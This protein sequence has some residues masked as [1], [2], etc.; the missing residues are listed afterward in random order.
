[1]TLR[2]LVIESQLVPPRQ[3]R[4]ILRRPRLEARLAAVLDY[5]LTLVQA[6]TGYGKSTALSALQGILHA[7][8]AGEPGML[9][10]YT[11]NETDRDPL[12]FLAHVVRAFERRAPSWGEPS[13]DIL[14]ASG[15][16]VTTD[17]LIPLINMLTNELDG[18]AILVLDDYHLVADVPEIEALVEYLVDY[19]PPKLHVVISGR[20]PPPLPA[21]SRWRAKGQ[22]LVVTRADL[23]FTVEEIEALFR[24]Q[25]EHPISREQAEVLAAETEGWAI[26]LQMVWQSLESSTAPSLDAALRLLPSSMEALFDYLAQE[27]LARQP[28]A[29]QRFL[30]TTSVLR[31]MDGASCDHLL[32]VQGSADTLRRLHE[33]GLFIVSTGDGAYRYHRLFHDF[34]RAHLDRTS[35]PDEVRGLHRRAADHFQRTGHAEETIHHLLEAQEHDRVA[36]SLEKIGPTLVR[37]GRFDSLSAWIARLPESVRA[38]RPGLN[39]LMGDTLRLRARFDEAL[40]HY[41]AAERRFV[42][43][44]DRLGHSRALRGQAQ[45]FLDTVR[46]LRA[47]SLLEQAL[48][49]LEPQ[50]HPQETAALLDQLAEN[51]LNLGYPDEAELLHREAHLLRSE[52]DP[53]SVFL[54]ARAKMRT[55]RLAEA[56]RLLEARAETDRQTAEFRPQRFHRE[57]VLLLSLLYALNGDADAA[58]RYAREGI[59]IGQ[60]LRS[61]YVEAVGYMRLG[62]AVQLQESRPWDTQERSVSHR[63]AACYHQAIQHIRTFNVLRTQVEPLWGLCLAHGAVGD[64]PSAERYALQALSIASRAGDQWIGNLV[65]LAMGTG[66]ALAGQSPQAHQWLAEA[67]EGFEKVGDMFGQS[68]AW[69]WQALDAW[70]RG[71]GDAALEHLARLLPRAREQGYD[72]LLVRRTLMGLKDDQAAA[73]LLIEAR[74]R[75]IEAEYADHLLETMHLAHIEHHPGYTLSVRTLGSFGVWRGTEPLGPRDWKR[76][77]AR[78]IFQ[79]LLTYRGQW[80]HREQIVEHLWPH[81]PPDAAARDFKVAL[82][83]LNHAL[84][85]GRLHGVPPFFVIRRDTLYGLNPDA[86]VSVDVDDFQRLAASDDA[87]SLRAALDLYEDDYLPDSLYEDWSS[88]LRQRLQHLY[89]DA[90]ERLAR[91]HLQAEAWDEA[92]QVCHAILAR[93]NCWEAAYRLLMQAYAAQENRPRVHSTYERCAAVLREELGVEPSPATQA[94]FEEL[95]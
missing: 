79:L 41:S 75:G 50:K 38:A 3:R 30:L 51:K 18:E 72:S 21:L 86:R 82:S 71:D 13:F 39:L 48:H 56:Q 83:A 89:L 85:P 81:L 46:P 70:R 73:P 64:L 74:R 4:G 23:A 27:V 61:A 84:E 34:L 91:L 78:Q 6:G 14:E 26:A 25:Y 93:D 52:A 5:P 10:W 33:R 55:G 11:I 15:G 32:R 60:R 45:V 16:R 24:E 8:D 90:A 28:A 35:P 12:L 42:E 68:A 58:T 65:R 88:P 80:F 57:A 53:D 17:A 20:R 31:Q 40:D 87:E 43:Q 92:I 7:A 63:A 77:K 36:Q 67:A 2:N 76:E 66:H 47:D 95:S 22:V 44:G 9:F 94:L 54:E 62:H 49:L 59:A 19:I 69:L 37:Q 29:V 1:M